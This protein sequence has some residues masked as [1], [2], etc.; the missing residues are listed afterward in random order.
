MAGTSPAMTPNKRFNATGSR[1][2]SAERPSDLPAHLNGRSDVLIAGGG[3]AG[4]ALAIAL[5]QALGVNFTV[6]LADPAVGQAGRDVRASAI[7][8]APR[9]MFEARGVWAAVADEAQPILDMV[10]T[11]SRVHDAVRPVFLTFGGEIEPGEPFAHMIENG[12]LIA[13]LA[14]R[15]AGAGVVLL[16]ASVVDFTAA[17]S[18]VNA[19]LSDGAA[20]SAGLLVAAD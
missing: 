19:V 6:T 7:A 10:I 13:A 17:P 9:R 18:A 5:R 15:A 8:A 1:S 11:D 3:F 16:K 2:S 4:F 20:I 12:R 14:A